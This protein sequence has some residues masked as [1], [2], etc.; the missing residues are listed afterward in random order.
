MPGYAEPSSVRRS[1]SPTTRLRLLLRSGAS[2]GRAHLRAG[3]GACAP[4]WSS[5][6]ASEVVP[7]FRGSLSGRNGPLALGLCAPVVPRGRAA[8]PRVVGVRR[9]RHPP[10]RGGRHSPVWRGWWPP[11]SG[12]GRWPSSTRREAHS[13]KCPRT[14]RIGESRNVC[15]RRLPRRRVSRRTRGQGLSAMCGGPGSCS[16]PGGAVY[17]PARMPAPALSGPSPSRG[18][19]AVVSF[20]RAAA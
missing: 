18:D 12:P 3:L 13:F 10:A 7:S 20:D 9:C 5:F 16:G 15:R 17:G 4:I 19:A 1:H 6:P 2:G 14:R 11:S 8:I